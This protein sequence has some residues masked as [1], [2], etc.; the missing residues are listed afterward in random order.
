MDNE[1][2]LDDFIVE[3]LILQDED[4]NKFEIT[5]TKRGI[6]IF[7]PSINE[8]YHVNLEIKNNEVQNKYNTK[9]IIPNSTIY[10]DRGILYRNYAEFLIGKNFETIDEKEFQIGDYK[11]K[12]NNKPSFLFKVAF[13]DLCYDDGYSTQLIDNDISTI[14]IQGKD[15]DKNNLEDKLSEAIFILGYYDKEFYRYYPDLYEYIDEYYID[16]TL[17]DKAEGEN[18]KFTKRSQRNKDTISKKYSEIMYPEAIR[19]YN[20]GM[21]IIDNEFSF[22]YFY[23]ILEYFWDIARKDVYLSQIESM[24]SS[25]NPEASYDT[26][27]K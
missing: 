20:A 17:F 7:E 6:R 27:K 9:Y 1:E 24:K 2:V 4:F 19:L 26:V 12:I 11:I 16:G 21:K 22:L 3:S 10:K 14:S 23:R 5:E 25:D 18:S 8:T 15:L 13:I